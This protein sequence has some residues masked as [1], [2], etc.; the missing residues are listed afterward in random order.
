MKYVDEML[1]GLKNAQRYIKLDICRAFESIPLAES[2]QKVMSFFTAA[3]QFYYKK[4]IQGCCDSLQV[5]AMIA[6][7]LLQAMPQVSCY[8]DDLVIGITSTI[9]EGLQIF[10]RLLARIIEFDL[11]VKPQKCQLLA[12]Q[13][14]ICG[15]GISLQIKRFVNLKNTFKVSGH[16]KA[17]E[18]VFRG[19]SVHM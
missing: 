1:H 2:S 13:T 16:K 5:W 14:E 18:T 15:Y 11:K 10:E 19:S 3:G 12:S 9:D 8:V 4:L 7:Q 17:G 6:S